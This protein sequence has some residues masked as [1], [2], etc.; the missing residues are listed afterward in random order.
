MVTERKT[1]INGRKQC[2]RIMSGKR[3]NKKKRCGM[4]AV[5]G[6]EHCRRHGGHR[7]EQNYDRI[8]EDGTPFTSMGLRR[9][10]HGKFGQL[11]ETMLAEMGDDDL[12]QELG[13]LRASLAT[14]L[15]ETS[16]RF[17]YWKENIDEMDS[18]ERAKYW[19][20]YNV[21]LSRVRQTVESIRK[22]IQTIADVKA[23]QDG[24]TLTMVQV[25][26]LVGELINAVMEIIGDDTDKLNSL[27]VMIDK[28]EWLPQ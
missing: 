21:M 5:D 4:W 28:L 3:G 19:K 22:V 12:S 13:S 18:M 24:N 9:V 26:L 1:A 23:K 10:V 17:E 15:E 8:V 16:A 2:A 6:S 14:Q 7:D 27:R 25:T 20:S 11:F